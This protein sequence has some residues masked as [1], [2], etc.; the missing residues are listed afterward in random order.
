MPD[1]TGIKRVFFDLETSPNLAMIWQPGFDLTIDHT[2]IVRERAIICGCYKWEGDPE[3][4]E[5]HWDR[6]Q[7]DERI[8]RK[9]AKVLAEADEIVSHNGDKFDLPWLRGRAIKWGIPFPH[10]LVSQDTCALAR[11]LFKFNSNRLDYLGKYLGFGGKIETGYGLWKSTFLDNDREALAKM[12]KYCKRDVDLLERV[13]KVFMPYV[14]AKSH[15]TGN[16]SDCP[17]CGSKH[18]TISKRRTTASGHRQVQLV[19]G[20]CGKYTTVAESR[21]KKV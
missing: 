14:A 21:W 17:E 6:K 7:S 11:R 16:I 18:L 2:S 10:R 13:W 12:I 9:L 15:G 19:C 8:V 5:V 1:S 3:I 20:D 4:H